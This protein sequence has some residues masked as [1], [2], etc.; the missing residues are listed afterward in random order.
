[1]C[2]LVCRPGDPAA[3]KAAAA[4][5]AAGSQ[6]AVASLTDPGSWKKSLEGEAPAGARLFLILPDG[7]VLAEANAAAR[8]LGE[9]WFGSVGAMFLGSALVEIERTVYGHSSPA[10]LRP[11]LPW[12]NRLAL[13]CELPASAAAPSSFMSAPSH[14]LLHVSSFTWSPVSAGAPL[15]PKLDLNV[16]SWLEWEERCLRPSIYGS[17]SAALA[18]AVGQLASALGAAGGQF[19]AGGQLS[20]A[21]I[22]VYATLSPLA[23]G[24]RSHNPTSQHAGQPAACATCLGPRHSVAWHCG[25]AVGPSQGLAEPLPVLPLGAGSEG[26]APVAAYLAGLA[27]QPAIS[28]AAQQ[29]GL[30]DGSAA[31]GVFLADRAEFRAARPRLPIPGQRNILITSALPYVNNVPHLGNII[32]CVLRCAA[33]LRLPS[34]RL[35]SSPCKPPAPPCERSRRPCCAAKHAAAL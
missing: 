21:D 25:A 10:S 6:L 34:P 24:R 27:A 30:A 29:V 28:A 35:Q 22:V 1:M 2:T 15:A 9:A 12:R 13:P 31:S 8:Y 23:G 17:D 7:S 5:A 20:L 32:G 33:Q 14:Q 26:V 11:T 4:A 16:E 19:L 3:L 18:A